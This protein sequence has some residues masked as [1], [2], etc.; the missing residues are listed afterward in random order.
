VLINV[1]LAP[2][3]RQNEI[4][5]FDGQGAL[6]IR[7]TAKPVEGEANRALVALL[8]KTLRLPKSAIEIKKGLSSK[9]KLVRIQGVEKLPEE[10]YG[11]TV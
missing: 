5:G 7:V 10:F 1:R 3:S 9:N 6:K 11:K 8:S 4:S 2:N